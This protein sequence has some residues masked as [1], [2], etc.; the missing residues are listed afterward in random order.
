[1]DRSC[2]CLDRCGR[3]GVGECDWSQPS[4][5]WLVSGLHLQREGAGEGA[6]EE[7]VG[8]DRSS[9]DWMVSF[10]VSDVCK[11]GVL[12]QS[13]LPSAVSMSGELASIA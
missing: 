12:D 11:S 9:I 13:G 1:M 5:P 2:I 8:Y 3:E 10:I 6:D 7:G 4:T